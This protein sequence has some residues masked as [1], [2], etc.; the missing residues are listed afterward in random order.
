MQRLDAD[1]ASPSPARILPPQQLIDLVRGVA[2]AG[3][4]LWVQVTGISM[5]PVIREGDSVLLAGFTRSPRSGDVVFLDIAGTPLL[6][7]VRQVDAGTIVTRGDAARMDDAPAAAAACVAQAVAVRRGSVMVAMTPTLR[8][9][10]K[11][12]LWF[13]AWEVRLRVPSS[14][15]PR[16]KPLSRAITR[17][18]S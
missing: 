3:G 9:G 11:A 17:A 8:F 12:L 10:V 5:N 14:L 15:G 18:L 1:R 7:R 2:S 16:V 4:A 13:A 6:H